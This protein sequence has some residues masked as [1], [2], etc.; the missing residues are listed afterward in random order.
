MTE[1]TLCPACGHANP[2]AAER[3][4][5]CRGP[6]AMVVDVTAATHDV[7]PPRPAGAA[8]PAE[9]EA[10]ALRGIAERMTQ[11]RA[12]AEATAPPRAGTPEFDAARRPPHYAGFVVRLVAF[13]IDIAILAAFTVPL[14]A[15]VTYG[16]R[17]GLVASKAP[18]RFVETEE[19]LSSLIGYAWLVM[20]ALYF[21]FLHRSTGQ[22][23]GKAV[24][25]IAVRRGRD[26]ARVGIF[27]SLLRVLGYA[28]STLFFFVGFTTVMMNRRKR[29]WHD[30]LAG[31]CVVH[32]AP[33]EV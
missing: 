5:S 14:V 8:K 21:A 7:T 12:A 10:A 26:L 17:T 9:D 27:R 24:V 2:I 32:L 1:T 29:G 19:A 33:E 16:V 20:A 30:Y 31:T 15:A 11:R 6:L 3:C 25:G 4:A 13:M 18:V 23:I 22:T 28:L